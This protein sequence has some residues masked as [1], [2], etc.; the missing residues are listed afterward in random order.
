M[1]D[2]DWDSLMTP[3]LE[4]SEVGEVSEVDVNL[5]VKVSVSEVEEKVILASLPTSEDDEDEFKDEDPGNRTYRYW[6]FTICNYTEDDEQLMLD[7]SEQSKCICVT[8]EVSK[9]GTPHL[10]GAIAMAGAHKFAHMKKMHPKAHWRAAKAKDPYF[11]PLKNDSTVVINVDWRRQGKRSDMEII[12]E[13]V[14]KRKPDKD[15]WEDHFG[16]MVR[17][18]KGINLSKKWLA[19]EI[20][21]IEYPIELFTLPPL[22][23]KKTT[24][25]WGKTTIGKSCY[26]KAHFRN[27]LWVNH[28]DDLGNWTGEQDGIIFDE[29]DIRTLPR[30]TQIHW[31]DQR[32]WRSLHCR[33]AVARIPPRTPKIFTTNEIGGHCM[34]LDDEAIAERVVIVNLGVNKLFI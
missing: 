33:Y 16:T 25:I 24:I 28:A 10:Q 27:P 34:S 30:T 17:N 26:A 29:M 23:L 20:I 15:L 3:D 31:V 2:L 18:N 19:P 13:H 21:E 7:W 5:D 8:K 6:V 11:Y 4:V 9:K 32:D 1:D 14:K 22:D 12:K